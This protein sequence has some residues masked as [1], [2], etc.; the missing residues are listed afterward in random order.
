MLRGEVGRE[1]EPFIGIVPARGNS[2]RTSPS[3][4]QWPRRGRSGAATASLV[5][6]S[7]SSVPHGTKSRAIELPNVSKCP[8][9]IR[10][11]RK[12]QLDSRIR[13]SCPSA[14]RINQ[15]MF[16]RMSTGRS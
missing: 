8:V 11:R 13:M 10:S 14:R 5:D 6:A 16:G 3:P 12:R 9:H 2:P 15:A 1:V 7:A 4:G